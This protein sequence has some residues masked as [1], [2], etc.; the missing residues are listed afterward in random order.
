L[1]DVFGGRMLPVTC[2]ENTI[3]RLLKCGLIPSIGLLTC[4]GDH[5]RLIDGDFGHGEA[6]DDIAV[7]DDEACGL[8]FVIVAACVLR[9][10]C[11]EKLGKPVVVRNVGEELLQRLR[12]IESNGDRVKFRQV[13]YAMNRAELAKACSGG[14]N[15]MMQFVPILTRSRRFFPSAA[16]RKPPWPESDC[17]RL[18]DSR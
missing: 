16:C 8:I 12:V 11:G 10:A 1:E 9:Q 13:A 4:E 7:A 18:K 15:P 6:A 2:A 5:F 14:S 3:D 17:C